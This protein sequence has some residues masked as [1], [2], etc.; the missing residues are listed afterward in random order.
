V[1]ALV[2]ERAARADEDEDPNRISHGYRFGEEPETPAW[3]PSPRNWNFELRFGPY[4]PGVDSEFADRG[5]TARPFEQTFSSK[6]RLMTGLEL[7]RQIL[8]RGGTLAIGF[9]FAFYR[10]T[11]NSLAGDLMTRTGDETSL[12]FYPLALQAVYRAD[13]LHERYGSPVV[14]FAKLGLDC[15]IWSVSNTGTGS[16]TR[17]RTFGWN[18]AAGIAL[19]LSFID[20]EGMRT[21]DS[22]TGVNGISLFGEV[23]HLGLDGFGSS[24]ALRLGATTWVAGLMMEM[25]LP[26][27]GAAPRP[28]SIE[29]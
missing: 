12:T 29:E 4:Y 17:G 3:S 21:M 24:S 11:A 8:H 18:A 25:G 26:T 19:D 22:E 15:A 13:F 6:Q 1:L 27:P 20:A 14:P 7:D 23:S 28:S 10:A 16:S 9:S 5:S 2:A